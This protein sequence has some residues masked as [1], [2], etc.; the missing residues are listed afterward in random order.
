MSKMRAGTA[1][2]VVAFALSRGLTITEIQDATGINC[3]ELMD[4]E[5]RLPDNVVPHLWLLL[6]DRFPQAPITLE[7]AKAAPFSIFGG[8]ADGAQYADDLQTAIDLLIKNRSI[9]ADR[10]EIELRTTET[11][12]V[13]S[14]Y[15]PADE[16]DGG[17]AAEMGSA[18][19]VRLLH[20]FLGLQDCIA[21]VRFAHAP[22]SD[23]EHYASYFGVPVEFEVAETAL[24]LRPEKLSARIKYANAALFKY[25]ETHF[26]GLQLQLAA[27]AQDSNELEALRRAVA[28]NA[29]TGEYGAAAA[30]AAANMSLRSAQRLTAHHGQSLQRMI[31]QV[32]E[33]QAKEFLSDSNIDL[34]SV[35]LLVG[36]S[37]DRAFRRAFQ[38][39]T[40][41]S[42]SDYRDQLKGKR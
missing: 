40:G 37:D 16:I 28:Q 12:A 36:Y 2:A 11:E 39:W 34:N 23:I 14:T 26:A 9:I 10:L 38:R 19:A 1:A 42:P 41:Q 25:V 22:H 6:G 29:V 27:T 8:L 20:N 17:R 18:I 13:L 21:G 33:D 24:L 32:R 3:Q 30:A 31:D 15:H 4:P 5:A 7:M 35:S